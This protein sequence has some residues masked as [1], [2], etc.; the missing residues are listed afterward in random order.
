MKADPS[1]TA[2]PGTF[3]TTHWSVVLNAGAE[4]DSRS[5][6]A[7]EVLCQQ[8]WY[9]L[10]AFAR[11]QGRT[12]PEAEDATQAFFAA[13]LANAG[14]ARARQD[15]GR[16]RTFLLTAFTHFLINE[17]RHATALKR[18]GGCAILPIDFEHGRQTYGRE[19][20]DPARAPERAFDRNWAAGLV[21]HAVDGLRREYERSHRG[22]LFRVLEPFLW[23]DQMDSLTRTAA[24]IGIEAHTLTMALFRLR[25]RFRERLRAEVAQTV[26]STE[27]VD[28]ELRH[29]LTIFAD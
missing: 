11:H 6:A 17:W 14:I 19:P 8:Y 21:N 2:P 12:H 25:A 16:F 5:F 1:L 4:S 29:L 13:L 18:G 20:M 7:L 3:P 28:D 23:G 10:Y 15:R 9:P 22:E 26:A 27:E 24:A